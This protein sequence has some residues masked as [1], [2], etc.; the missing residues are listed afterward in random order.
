VF[1]RMKWRAI[2]GCQA[3]AYIA[4]PVYVYWLRRRPHRLAE[5]KQ[6]ILMAGLLAQ[7]VLV[8]AAGLLLWLA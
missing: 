8:G 4:V 5:G 6:H 2:G 7:R 3:A 1:D